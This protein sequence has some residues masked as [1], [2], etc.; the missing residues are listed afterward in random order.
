MDTPQEIT[1][2]KCGESKPLALFVTARD[3]K[4]GVKRLCKN[5]EADRLAARDSTPSGKARLRVLKRLT[6]RRIR[7]EILVA[8]G[9]TCKCC[10]ETE[11]KFLAVDH[12]YNDG[13]EHRRLIKRT[14]GGQFYKWL[15]QHGYPQ[16]RY[17]LLCH[18]CNC[19]KGYYGRCPHEIARASS[20]NKTA[21]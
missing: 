3:R 2:T 15:R 12:I 10:G 6:N 9:G 18:N 1:C 17:Q 21:A 11:P 7:Q 19:A 16:D 8:Y 13:G 4:L 14:A 20:I 5:C